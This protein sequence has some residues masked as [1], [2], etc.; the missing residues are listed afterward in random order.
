MI[1]LQGQFSDQIRSVQI[2]EKKRQPDRHRSDRFWS[3]G[4]CRSIRDKKK[5]LSAGLLQP[6]I[7]P[8]ARQIAESVCSWARRRPR[9]RVLGSCRPRLGPAWIVLPSWFHS[10]PA[11]LARTAERSLQCAPARSTRTAPSRTPGA[12]ARIAGLDAPSRLTSDGLRPLARPDRPCQFSVTTVFAL[13]CIGFL[14]IFVT[15]Y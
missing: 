1:D 8:H 10:G 6:G 15:D 2:Q 14:H 3:P 12:L 7:A 11:H 13:V 5:A 4:H 9:D